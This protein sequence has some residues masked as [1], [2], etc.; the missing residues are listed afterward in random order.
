MRRCHSQPFVH[1]S[2]FEQMAEQKKKLSEALLAE[3]SY[4]AKNGSGPSAMDVKDILKV[5]TASVHAPSPLANRPPAQ[6]RAHSGAKP[7]PPVLFL[8]DADAADATTAT[9]TSAGANGHSDPG[10]TTQ[11][12]GSHSTA[13]SARK[14]KRIAAEEDEEEEEDEDE[15]EHKEARDDKGKN[16]AK[17]PS[18][19]SAKADVKDNR[20]LVEKEKANKRQKL[21]DEEPKTRTNGSAT[22]KMATTTEGVKKAEAASSTSS[23]TTSKAKPKQLTLEEFKRKY[24]T[25]S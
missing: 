23:S 16:R 14:R 5:I 10:R 18:Q 8:D 3:G 22:K 24:S 2:L 20:A 17:A 13:E 1:R 15:E 19:N 4:A 21:E 11:R 9:T 7:K 12:N 6:Q 25:K